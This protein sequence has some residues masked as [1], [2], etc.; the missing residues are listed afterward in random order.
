M[1]IIIES[2]LVD[3]LL[4]VSVLVL[5][6][7]FSYAIMQLLKAK[8]EDI[9]LTFGQ[10]IPGALT[11]VG[12][13]FTFLGIFLAL[14]FLDIEDISQSIPKLLSGLKL[15]FL[16]SVLGLLFALLYRFIRWLRTS[17]SSSAESA[18]GILFEMNSNLN[19]LVE[20]NIQIK[21][22][23]VGDGN[24]SLS[25]HLAKLRI[26][27]RDFADKV[28]ADSTQKLVEALE[29]V[30]RDFNQK[31]TEQFG[32]NFKQL[33][34]AVSAMLE[35]QKEH[36]AHVEVLTREFKNAQEGINLTKECIEEIE[37]STKKIPEQMEKIDKVFDNCNKRVEELSEGLQSLAVLREKAENSIPK[38]Q[39]HVDSMIENLQQSVQKQMDSMQNYHEQQKQFGTSLKT[40]ADETNELMNQ[41]YKELDTKIEE[42]TRGALEKMS[43]NLTPILNEINRLYQRQI[44]EIKEKY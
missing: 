11:T 24:S 22:A 25:T 31:I 8:K 41:T 5:V 38:I 6:G 3:K 37:K 16:S 27:F 23:L 28:T 12:I 18:E 1:S 20:G 17:K 33:N 30:I 44:D 21:D 35:W 7:F 10:S 34:E 26:E 29:N 43:N 13:F 9:N 39:Q 32:D 14:A 4:W 15:A 2:L 42:I 19:K 36:K 40:Q